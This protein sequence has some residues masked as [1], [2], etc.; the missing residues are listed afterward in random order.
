MLVN[1]QGCGDQC[2]RYDE[3]ASNQRAAES[4]YRSAPGDETKTVNNA[5]E[6]SLDHLAAHLK[7][8]DSLG[9]PAVV[10]EFGLGRDGENP[11]PTATVSD[12]DTYLT[13]VLAAGARAAAEGR[14]F[15][16]TNI[17]S[18]GGEGRAAR[19][20]AVWVEGTDF[21]GDPPQEPQGLNS[22]FDKDASTLAVIR[23]HAD[24]LGKL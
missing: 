10:E 17:W 15:A 24:A 18:W 5:V 9:K 8:A 11:S 16:G 22:I 3:L 1:N 12:R 6:R 2:N 19:K 21:T 14:A 20:N 23:T 13:A 7:T 4:A